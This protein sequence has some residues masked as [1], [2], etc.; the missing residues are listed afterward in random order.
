M[1]GN[2]LI[3]HILHDLLFKAEQP[4]IALL[5]GDVMVNPGR[6]TTSSSTNLATIRY[7][8]FF[9]EVQSSKELLQFFSR[10]PVEDKWDGESASTIPKY[11]LASLVHGELFD[12][13]RMLS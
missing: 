10:S 6:L 1:T 2:A 8:S 13:V 9:K 4:S 5:V 3:E 7:R 11:P 12:T